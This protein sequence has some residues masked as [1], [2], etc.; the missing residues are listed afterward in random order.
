[1]QFLCN[2]PFLFVEFSHVLIF[3]MLCI[4][5][6]FGEHCLECTTFL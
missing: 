2:V 3:C 1:M 6:E 5:R 4:V